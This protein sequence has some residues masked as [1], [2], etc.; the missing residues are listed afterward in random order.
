MKAAAFII[1]LFMLLTEGC[2][3]GPNY[4]PPKVV[5]PPTFGAAN[6]SVSTNEPVAN[7]WRQFHDAELDHLVAEALR[8]NYDIQI[9]TLR[10]REARFQ[11]NIAAA[12]LFP[13]VDGTGSYVRSRGSK[14]VVLPLGNAGGSSGGNGSGSS[15]KAEK[16]KQ[17]NSSD[18]SPSPLSQQPS[19]FGQGGLPGATTDLYQVG[20]DA[21]WEVDVFGGKRRQVQAAAAE[22]E[23]AA[24]GRR[25]LQVSLAAETARDYLELRGGQE[26]LQIARDNLVA[27]R[28]ILALTRS[29]EVEGLSTHLDVL[30][31]ESE[32]SQTESTLPPLEANVRQMMHALATLLARNPDDL[33]A[34]LKEF[35]AVPAA[36]PAVPVGLPSQLLQ[37][38]ADIKEAERE[39]AAA[40]ARIGVAQSDLFPKFALIGTLGLDSSQPGNLFNWES[41]YFLISP[42]VTWRIFDAGRI[43]SNIRLQN[44]NEQQATLRYRNTVLKALR[45]VEDALVL[46]ASERARR[47][48]LEDEVKQNRDALKLARDQYEKGLVDFISV[49]D[50][51]RISL[52]SQDALDM[53]VTSVA[54]DLVALYKS[55]GGGWD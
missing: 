15:S 24:A 12:D 51:E 20:F 3:V 43:L 28:D 6:G 47:N 35:E 23:A 52:S 37:R 41:R 5:T 13:T 22:A 4:H 38:R 17:E 26:R 14:N 1:L 16:P 7:W 30:R 39:I 27:Q 9:A 36:P 21:S 18:V 25:D 48:H 44:A 34:E 19:P 45:E 31:A 32:V 33:R 10:I 8:S 50:A 46:Y 29:K 55:L 54:T 40:S 11:R 2:A 49:L 53:S 42:T